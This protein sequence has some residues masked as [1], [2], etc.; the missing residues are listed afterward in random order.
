MR[1]FAQAVQFCIDTAWQYRITHKIQLQKQCYYQVKAR[2]G[3][4]A[5]LVINAIAQTIEMIRSAKSKPQVSEA[6]SIRYNFP[7][8]ASISRNWTTLSLATLQG[9][10]KFPVSIPKVFKKYLDWRLCESTLIRDRKGRF[11]FCF[12]F[13]KEV[14]TYPHRGTECKIV[15][16]DLGVNTLAVTSD[17]RFFGSIIHR[18]IQWER[19]V[20]KLQAKG[21]RAAKRRLR[22]AS[23]AWKRFMTWINHTVSKRILNGLSEGDVLVLEDLTD[24]RKT[25][26]YNRWVHRWAFRELQSFLEYKAIRKGIRVVYV[27]P[28]YTSKEC[29]RCHSRSTKRTRGFFECRVC[30]HT[31]N[32]DLNGA[33]NIALRYMR[34]TGRGL[35]KQAHDL[36]CDEVETPSPTDGGLKRSTAK[37]LTA[38]T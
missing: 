34:I 2:Y 33:R 26:K 11:M 6:F 31:L 36:A 15:G 17:A 21:T 4:Q 1:V 5:Q 9:R 32:A 30:G 19:R 35:G 28:H 3:L 20:A 7:R 16:V 22:R 14:D 29:N 8:S 18:R 37:S 24:I 13:A 12:V 10:V 23:G 38:L 25:A 27:R